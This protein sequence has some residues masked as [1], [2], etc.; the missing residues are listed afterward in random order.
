MFL[1]LYFITEAY[2]EKKKFGFGH[3][4]G[5]I[6]VMGIGVSAILHNIPGDTSD[7]ILD[8][9]VF[10]KNIFFDLLLPLIVFPSGYNMRRKKFFS[11]IGTIMK[12]GFIGTIFCFA[13]YTGMCYGLLEAG[14]LTKTDDT[15]ATVPLELG[16]YEVICICSLLCSS[17]VI[18]AISMISYQDQ[19]KLFSIVYG[20]GVFNDIVSIILFNTVQ[21]FATGF[22]PS[23][24]T[25]FEIAG[26]FVLLA[27]SSIGI[28]IAGGFFSSLLF[29]HCRFLSHSSITETLLLLVIAMI[30]YFT[31]AVIE[32]S[33]MISLLVCGII[34]AHYTWYNL[35]PQ[36]KTISSI[37]ISVF[38]SAAEATVF[39]YIGLCT[40]TY[41]SGQG[42]TSSNI[43][44][45]SFIG[46]MT[47]VIILG[48]IMAVWL[49]HGMFRFCCCKMKDI[50]I[51]ELIFISYGGM[52]RGA[53]AFGLVL[54]IPE[55]AD[56]DKGIP[57]FK[58]RDY[59]VTTTLAVV[60]IT[61][62]F[63]GSFMP[64]ISKLLFGNAED[65]AQFRENLLEE[66]NKQGSI[67]QD[68]KQ[69]AEER[70]VGSASSHYAS[71][72]H[73]NME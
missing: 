54:K 59:V 20:E 1:S 61:T 66:H 67:G 44:S 27:L 8:D 21:G 15:G 40:F 69:G 51:K 65:D 35:S 3:T 45:I 38:G 6:V 30:C 58:D 48:R 24:S 64:V 60:I 46:W 73:P 28:G 29:K 13:I 17:D 11:N 2:F 22:N 7:N 53:I 5:I 33:E 4:T 47:V 49:V 72:K 70:P 55:H 19:P 62:L 25:P 63:F 68:Q 31:A 37:T 23:I 39:A 18:A 52:I 56:P 36:G 10:D 16:P 26:N 32:Q 42:E 14:M 71:L 57:E 50:D 9:L 43:W 34:M 41:A 12:F